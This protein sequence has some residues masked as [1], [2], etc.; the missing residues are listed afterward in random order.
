H[1]P[2]HKTNGPMAL[3]FFG[4]AGDGN[5]TGTTAESRKKG[6]GA[7][8][9]STP[10]ICR[11]LLRADSAKPSFGDRRPSCNKRAIGPFVFWL[12]G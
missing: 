2:L 4:S 10:V 3:L 1:H 11:S 12:S 6:R 7:A 8:L 9:F 5:R